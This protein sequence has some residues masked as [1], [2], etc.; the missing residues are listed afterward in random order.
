MVHRD[1]KME[2]LLLDANFNLKINDF[3]FQKTAEAQNDGM[4]LCQTSIGTPAY[5]APETWL[6]S[7]IQN[8]QYDGKKVDIYNCGVILFCCAL[9]ASPFYVN[10]MQGESQQT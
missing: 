6:S 4:I 2:N 7:L 3:G 9:R 5:Q 8:P 1:L 10:N